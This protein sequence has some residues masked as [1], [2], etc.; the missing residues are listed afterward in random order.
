MSRH[1]MSQSHYGFNTLLEYAAQ[2]KRQEGRGRL[3][4]REGKKKTSIRV[5]LCLCTPMC[6]PPGHAHQQSWHARM[7]AMNKVYVSHNRPTRCRTLHRPNPL[8]SFSLYCPYLFFFPRS[9]CKVKVT[10]AWTGPQTALRNELNNIDWLDF[11]CEHS[12]SLKMTVLKL[13]HS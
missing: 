9:H 2:R 1:I 6:R 5:I 3:G 8:F 7:H 12:A 11:W 13:F 10:V 4:G